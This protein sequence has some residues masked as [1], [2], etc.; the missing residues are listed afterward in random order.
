MGSLFDV[1][2][3]VESVPEVL[4]YLPVTLELAAVASLIGLALGFLIALARYFHVRVLSQVCVAFVSI[5]R[6]T[7]A[8]C[9]LLLAYYGI[10]ILLRIVNYQFGTELAVSTADPMAFAIVAM[11]L[12]AAAFMSETIRSCMESVDSGQLEACYSV[13]L[14]SGQAIWHVVLPQAFASALAPLGNTVIGVV[15][16][17]SL[18]FNISVIEMMSAA[19]IIGARNYRFFEV[20]VVVSVIYWVI[21]FLLERL[22]DVCERRLRKHERRDA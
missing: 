17:T 22:I 20:Y 7:P 4:S 13:G 19:K 1:N 5:M 14:T 10:P 15:K 2:F 16:D 21:C 3:L 6:G 11:G 8:M 12:N 9:Q 18:V